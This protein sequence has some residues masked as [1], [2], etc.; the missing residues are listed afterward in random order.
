M[1]INQ[2]AKLQR[3]MRQRAHDIL[4]ILRC[5]EP[6][7]DISNYSETAQL[8]PMVVMWQLRVEYVTSESGEDKTTM[9]IDLPNEFGD[10][11]VPLNENALVEYIQKKQTDQHKKDLFDLIN[12]TTQKLSVL[13]KTHPGVGEKLAEIVLDRIKTGKKFDKKILDNFM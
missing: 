10:V 6:K 8:I 4:N 12:H 3:A 9:T 13:N 1:N 2:A 5:I 7:F 11:S